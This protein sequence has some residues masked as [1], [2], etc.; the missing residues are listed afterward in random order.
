MAGFATE[1]WI[2]GLLANPGDKHYFGSTK[3]EG[4]K[5]WRAKVDKAREKLKKP[6]QEA[7]AQEW[8]ASE[9]KEFDKIANWL[10]SPDKPEGPGKLL[11]T[12]TC[13]SCHS[14]QGEGGK[15][16]PDMTAYGSASWI[17]G[18]IMDPAHPSRYGKNN[19]MPAFRNMDGPGSEFFIKELQERNE[20]NDVKVTSMELSDIDRELI[21]RWMTHDDRVVFG[22]KTIA[23]PPK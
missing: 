16:A 23:A 11:F 9:E 13:A 18:M 14:F 6:G 8:I 4:M 7:K 20:K 22:G 19:E 12:E 1:K 21:I 2:R 15:N 17:R 5:K 10:A 3:L